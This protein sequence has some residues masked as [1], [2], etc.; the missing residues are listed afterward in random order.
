MELAKDNSQSKNKAKDNKALNNY[1]PI[2][3]FPTTSSILL[4]RQSTKDNIILLLSHS[5]FCSS[6]WRF[7]PKHSAMH[8]VNEVDDDAITLFENKQ[9]NTGCALNLSKSFNTICL[10]LLATLVLLL[11]ICG[12]FIHV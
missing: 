3:L 11:F 4:T 9:Y 1:R 6:R 2:S 12:L 5:V 7:R 10:Q 8:V